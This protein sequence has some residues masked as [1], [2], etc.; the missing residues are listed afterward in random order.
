M[1]SRVVMVL[2]G[3]DQPGLVHKLAELLKA[4]G[5]N[6][7]ESRMSRLGGEF[8]GILRIEIPASRLEE[9][10]L[11]VRQRLSG[12]LTVVMRPDQ[13]QDLETEERRLGRLELTAHDRPGLI[14]AVSAVLAKYQVNVE[15]LDTTVEPAPMTSEQLFRASMVVR[16]PVPCSIRRLREELENTAQDLMVD[17][18]I[19]L[20][21]EQPSDVVACRVETDFV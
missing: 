20:P 10:E 16:L 5:A 18:T 19:D 7:L 3:R 2:V 6:W 12:S 15:Q 13:A 9:L 11:L 21:P 17:L 4:V 8:A 14:E 1:K